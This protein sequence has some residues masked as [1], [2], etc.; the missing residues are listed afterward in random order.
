MITWGRG[1][2]REL[3][4]KSILLT[5]LN[6]NHHLIIWSSDH[7]II[8]SSEHLD[9][10]DESQL[11][12]PTWPSTSDQRGRRSPSNRKSRKSVTV[13]LSV[14]KYRNSKEFVA[15]L[16]WEAGKNATSTLCGTWRY[17]LECVSECIF[18]M[19]FLV[20]SP[21]AS[22]IE[23]SSYFFSNVFSLSVKG[24]KSDLN[25]LWHSVR[26]T[27]VCFWVYFLD[28][29]FSVFSECIFNWIFK[30]FFFKCIFSEC[31]R[32]KV[33]PQLFVALGEID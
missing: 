16:K 30:L 10:L 24:K 15:V 13:L 27:R 20:Y 29:F 2:W 28:G 5:D 25:S 33:R 17:W 7:L 21:S 14:E 6:D 31:E 32:E 26:L 19:D 11:A 9:F 22:L 12:S 3:S 4:D 23:F 8:G 1:S 18:W